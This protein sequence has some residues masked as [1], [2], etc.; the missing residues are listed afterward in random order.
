M[1]NPDAQSQ[2]RTISD[3]DV[4]T[5][6]DGY[7]YT[8][9][10]WAVR[11]AVTRLAERSG[12]LHADVAVWGPLNGAEK[13]L[14]RAYLN[15]SSLQTRERLPK[16][17]TYL[18]PGP[19]WDTVIET[20]CVRTVTQH[21]EG[22]PAERLEPTEQDRAAWFICNPLVY[23]RHPTLIYGPGESGK[24]LFALYVACL[25]ASGGTSTNL[26]V[27]PDGHEVLYL[28]WE[29][30]APEMRARVR[31]L[32]AAH[33]ELSKTP[34]HRWMH[35]PLVACAAEIRRDIQRYG[36]G[37]VVIDSL[38]PATGGEIERASDPVQFFNALNSLGVASLLI[39]H[40]AK[41]ADDEK[42]RT[43][44]GSVYYYNLARSIYE[45]RLVSEPD[46]DQRKIALYHRKNNFGR[47]RHLGYT[48][49]IT[50]AQARFEEFD[51]AEEPELAHG[52]SLRERIKNLLADHQT[53]TVEA[54]S[55]A[56]SVKA[57]TVKTTL[58]RYKGRD[59][60][61]LSAGGG[62]GKEG[63]WAVM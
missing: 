34:W 7:T 58:N 51:P 24:S 27:A 41:P 40:V 45:V 33:P 28:N 38:G 11:V 25:L 14:T 46:S 19:L 63:E 48:L 52:L 3:L 47:K 29:M 13:L 16:R 60:L 59:W 23:E 49:T 26:A 30:Q 56:L 39:G 8:W 4:G 1:T 12:H 55:E 2:E 42:T 15:L 10:S 54:I 18:C 50:D 53:R 62:R 35:L 36:I 20:I 32:R 31:Q 61:C 6:S 43:P 22:S 37:V 21:R 9:H 5:D 57:D 17:L 44:Y